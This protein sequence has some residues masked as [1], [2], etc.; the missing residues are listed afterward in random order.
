LGVDAEDT[1]AVAAAVVVIGD[2]VGAS[3]KAL[4]DSAKEQTQTMINLFI[5][6]V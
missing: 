5:V 2:A 6:G 1:V 3:A 4:I